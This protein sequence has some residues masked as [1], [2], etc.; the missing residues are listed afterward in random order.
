MSL[1]QLFYNN[2]LSSDIKYYF[3]EFNN[4]YVQKT[5]NQRVWLAAV[6][7]IIY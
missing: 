7:V 2:M 4:K 6:V 5:A 1:K 3:I